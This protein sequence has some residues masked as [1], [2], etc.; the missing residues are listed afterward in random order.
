MIILQTKKEFNKAS[1]IED[2]WEHLQAQNLD[3]L[4]DPDS[5]EVAEAKERWGINANKDDKHY[6]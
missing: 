4:A 2:T 6:C 1:V 3:E 5:E